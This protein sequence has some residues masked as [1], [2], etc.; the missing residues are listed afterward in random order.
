MKYLDVYVLKGK[1][2]SSVHRKMD[3]YKKD[4]IRF[5]TNEY[6]IYEMR[7][8]QECCENVYIEDIIGDLEDLVGSPI[9]MAEKVTSKT[10]PEVLKTPEYE[11]YSRTWTFYKFATQKGY[12]TIRW[13]GTSNGYYSE[14]VDFDK[15]END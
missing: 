9:I 13:Y 5:T 15:V 3:P 14:S 8:S 12:V 2:L 10:N 1:T 11:D 7:H 4:F 6:E